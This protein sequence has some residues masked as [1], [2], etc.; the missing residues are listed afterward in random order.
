MATTSTGDKITMILN[1]TV[2]AISTV[3]PLSITMDKPLLLK[4][5]VLQTE[6]GVLIG[7][8]GDVRGRLILEG[9]KIVFCGIGEVLFGM[10]LEGE[11][12]ES[13]A[14]E[15]G[16]MI[17]GNVCTNVFERGLKIDITPPTVMDGKVK[18]SGFDKA[19]CVPV[20]IDGKGT[21]NMIL[22]IE[23]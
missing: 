11:M 16:N 12:L 8:T 1:G 5:P 7:V 15:I 20:H 2:Q 18:L 10:A 23:E 19:I 6:I 14:G 22:V 17:A 21:L 9:A 13:F 4:A 3:I